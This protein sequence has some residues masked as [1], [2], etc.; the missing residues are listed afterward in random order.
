MWREAPLTGQ[1]FLAYK[2]LAPGF[3]DEFFGSPHNE[4]LRLF[5]ESGTIVGLLGLAFIVL[6]VRSLSRVPGW[7]GTGLLTGFVGYVIAASFNNP[8]LFIRVS[9]VAFPMIGVGL[10]LAGLARSAVVTPTTEEP[11]GHA[12]DEAASPAEFANPPEDAGGEDAEAEGAND[13]APVP[14]EDARDEPAE[15]VSAEPPEDGVPEPPEDGAP[16]PAE[17]ATA[18]LAEPSSDDPR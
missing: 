15:D 5:A 4:W 1:G 14:A 11:P 16:E 7:L 10:A 12:A 2:T 6:A 17:G 13:G 3:G 9:A 18:E 8:F